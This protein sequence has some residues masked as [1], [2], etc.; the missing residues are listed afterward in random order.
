MSLNL[1]PITR[2]LVQHE[3]DHRAG[4]TL[5]TSDVRAMINEIGRLNHAVVVARQ[6]AY[7]AGLALLDHD[8]PKVRRFLDAI[9]AGRDP[10]SPADPGG[11]PSSHGLS[12][13][14][15]DVSH[16]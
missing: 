7:L 5:S 14:K 15:G 10:S 1:G 3:E 4:M 11:L 8:L 2:V 16:E 6:Y 9:A 12:P 13:N